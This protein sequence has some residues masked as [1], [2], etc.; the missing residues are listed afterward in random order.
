MTLDL[1]SQL[2]DGYLSGWRGT[3]VRGGGGRG[4]ALVQA[5]RGEE[6]KK[7]EGTG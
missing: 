1:R 3:E 5:G 7:G 4:T 2:P 6:E